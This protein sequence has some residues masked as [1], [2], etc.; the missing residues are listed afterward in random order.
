MTDKERAK[1]RKTQKSWEMHIVNNIL[2][3]PFSKTKKRKKN[4]G[5][6]T[7]RRFPYVANE[8]PD[9]LTSEDDFDFGSDE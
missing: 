3:A 8:A 9:G 4:R 6:G 2:L 7:G 1:I 5:K